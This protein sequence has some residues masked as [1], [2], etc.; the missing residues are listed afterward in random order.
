MGNWCLTVTETSRLVLRLPCPLPQARCRQQRVSRL[1]IVTGRPRHKNGDISTCALLAFFRRV[2][3][4]R[5][6]MLIMSTPSLHYSQSIGLK[7]SGQP[8]RIWHFLV[9][10]ADS[11]TGLESLTKSAIQTCTLSNANVSLLTNMAHSLICRGLTLLHR[12][13]SWPIALVQFPTEIH[14]CLN[15]LESSSTLASLATIATPD[16]VIVYST[17]LD[18]DALHSLFFLH[19]RC[20]G[21][22]PRSHGLIERND[23]LYHGNCNA[24][25]TL[26]TRPQL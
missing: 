21:R 26:L 4:S 22:S 1:Q 14:P 18:Q 8:S 20:P 23:N 17:P 16:L 9:P 15:N 25:P 6:L 24:K 3:S 5:L 7:G 11:L 13:L 12:S 2:K 10:W 19:C